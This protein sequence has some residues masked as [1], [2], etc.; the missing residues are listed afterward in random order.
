M[1][2]YQCSCSDRTSVTILIVIA[3]QCSCSD[4]PVSLLIVIAYQCSIVI[5]C[6]YINC[7]SLSMLYSDRTSVTI[8]IVIAYQLM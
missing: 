7:D 8:L 4:I 3:Y 5:V 6:H 1:I 2:A